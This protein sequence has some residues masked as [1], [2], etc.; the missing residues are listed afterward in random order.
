MPPPTQYPVARPGFVGRDR[1]HADYLA[2]V[3][4]SRKI[5]NLL[6]L[7]ESKKVP[8]SFDKAGHGESAIKFDYSC[9]GTYIR[10]NL[11]IATHCHDG[12]AND[13]DRLRVAYIR[14]NAG[15]SAAAQ[16]QVG[17]DWRSGRG[18]LFR[19]AA[20]GRDQKQTDNR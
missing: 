3:V 12:S 6:R 5:E 11:G 9:R 7:P 10:C 4:D 19:R 14:I 20:T 18:F 15:N 13:G 17:N 2:P 16:N 8:M 1:N